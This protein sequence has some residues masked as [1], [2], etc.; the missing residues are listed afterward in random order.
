MTAWAWSFLNWFAIAKG[1]A[2][3]VLCEF[4][5]SKGMK[6]YMVE[7]GGEVRCS[8]RNPEGK[9]W[10][11]GIEDPTVSLLERELFATAIIENGS[12]ATSGN[13]RNFY[14]KDGK[15]YVH[16]ISPFTGFPVED[17]LLS[18]SVLVINV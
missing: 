8:G 16:T 9:A 15:K 13:Y 10:R 12:L 7:I 14:E 5:E 11:I 1:Y 18:V 2:V 4:L 3:D 6:D 17:S